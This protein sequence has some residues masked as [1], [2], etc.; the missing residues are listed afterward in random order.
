MP[1]GSNSMNKPVRYR[2]MLWNMRLASVRTRLSVT[3]KRNTS[4][5][6]IKTARCKVS[7]AAAIKNGRICTNPYATAMPP[8]TSTTFPAVPSGR[9]QK[10]FKP[11]ITGEPGVVAIVSPYPKI[12]SNSLAFWKFPAPPPFQRRRKIALRLLQPRTRH[13]RLRLH[14]LHL[15][16]QVGNFF[17]LLLNGLIQVTDLGDLG[18]DFRS[19]HFVGLFVESAR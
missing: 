14:G 3:M 18:I 12:V 7:V 11:C 13:F 19:R 9:C 10:F 2:M 6:P 8:R 16:L 1:M 15:L 17:L 5:P 4:I